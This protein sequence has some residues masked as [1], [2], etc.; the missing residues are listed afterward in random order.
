MY[1]IIQG[2]VGEIMMDPKFKMIGDKFVEYLQQ[3]RDRINIDFTDIISS[4]YDH[5][6]DED[7]QESRTFC[8]GIEVLF[9]KVNGDNSDNVTLQID[10]V[11]RQGIEINVRTAWGYPSGEIVELM[12][13]NP[14]K[15]SDDNLKLVQLKLPEMIENF[16][17]EIKDN[18][19]G[20]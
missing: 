7:N 5:Q 3:E 11:E 4:V 1:T 20:K 12:F 15:V 19:N 10:V 17:Q 6:S 18:P 9:Q 2:F 8:I 13:E 14:L 16:R